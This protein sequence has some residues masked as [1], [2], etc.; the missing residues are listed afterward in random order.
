MAQMVEALLP[1][2]LFGAAA[3]I[4][5]LAPEAAQLAFHVAEPPSVTMQ[6]AVSAIWLFALLTCAEAPTVVPSQIFMVN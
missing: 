1:A 4:L 5:L 2:P 6:L 3:A